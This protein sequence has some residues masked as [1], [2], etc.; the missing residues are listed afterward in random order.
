M[1]GILKLL[2]ILVAILYT[3]IAYGQ[4]NELITAAS[5]AKEVDRKIAGN[6][7]GGGVIA[8]G[9][10]YRGN[11]LIYQYNVPNDWELFDGARE[12]VLDQLKK[13]GIAESYQKLGI[14]VEYHYYKNNNF[15]DFFGITKDEWGVPQKSFN[16]RVQDYLAEWSYKPTDLIKLKEIVDLTDHPKS[17]GLSLTLKIPYGWELK[18]GSRPNV[19]KK[20]T[21]QGC[22]FLVMVKDN[23]TFLT[24][25]EAREI[26]ED[27]EYVSDFIS[28]VT[29]VLENS[30]L[31]S[32]KLIVIDNYPALEYVVKGNKNN[33]SGIAI[34]VRSKHWTL[35]FE[36]KIVSF[37]MMGPD[38]DSF[39]HLEL[40]SL[41]I[42]NSVVFPEQYN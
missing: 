5:I 6:D 2:Y 3:S 20:F 37:S 8:R 1:K 28:G 11:T 38:N 39:D 9:C 36:D 18:E 40:I 12:N 23:I 19:V 14:G 25:S 41:M 26:F 33:S 30:S 42:I 32:S 24:R 15:H 31:I 4:N 29:S 10:T 21:S 22:T 27:K 7:L 17:K 35:F 16:D 34:V 13:K